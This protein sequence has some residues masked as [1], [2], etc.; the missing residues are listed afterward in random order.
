[1][2]THIVYSEHNILYALFMLKNTKDSTFYILDYIDFTSDVV[3]FLAKSNKYKIYFLKEKLMYKFPK[4]LRLPLYLVINMPVLLSIFKLKLNYLGLSNENET[5]I[6][7]DASFTGIFLRLIG[8]NHSLHEGSIN[9]F[10]RLKFSSKRALL[11][12]EDSV[13]Q[14]KNRPLYKFILGYG[15]SDLVNRIYVTD[16]SICSFIVPIEKLFR[17]PEI[18]LS[19]SIRSNYELVRLIYKDV[20]DYLNNNIVYSS[21]L[22][23]IL[24]QPINSADK[25]IQIYREILI[26]ARKNNAM[27]IIK[28]HPRD[29]LNYSILKDDD[30]LILAKGF[31]V[32][33]LITSG[34]RFDN[35]YT[36]SSSSGIGSI[37]DNFI[38]FEEKLEGYVVGNLEE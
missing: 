15:N 17:I 22:D 25:R 13:R 11:R 19:L 3:R 34:I 21:K 30:V 31:P 37:C 6:Y 2:K 33:I 27:V 9:Y 24:T 28:P 26:E 7:N 8:L 1:M 4:I 32:E 5:V 20:F 10:A 12:R 35:C 16:P 36:V 38:N 18:T 29:S 23:L 14:K